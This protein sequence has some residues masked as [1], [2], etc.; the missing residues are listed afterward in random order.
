MWWN[1]VGRDHDEVEA[2]R[3][4]WQRAVDGAE[5]RFGQVAAYDGAALPAPALPGTRLRPRRRS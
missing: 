3:E 1:F 5:T 2:S 4:E